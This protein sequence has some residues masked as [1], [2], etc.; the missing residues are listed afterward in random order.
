MTC[1][2]LKTAQSPRATKPV[3]S[4]SWVGSCPRARLEHI[5]NHLAHCKTEQIP[6]FEC[7]EGALTSL[8]HLYNA[9]FQSSFV[10]HTMTTTI[11]A[12]H[13]TVTEGQK[14]IMKM[15]KYY[16]YQFFKSYGLSLQT[17]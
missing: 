7:M 8:T 1:P 5:T 9:A 16:R 15:I 10:P 4:Q 12:G 6:V 2:D 11:S 13:K 14:M 3:R 17:Y